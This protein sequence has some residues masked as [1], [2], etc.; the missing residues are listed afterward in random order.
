MLGEY[1]P[2]DRD[3]PIQQVARLTGTTSRTLRHYEAKGLLQPSRVATNG[4]RFYDA[5]TLVRLQR[6]LLL[7]QLG[8]SLSAIGEALA[9]Q[10]SEITALRAHLEQLRSEQARVTR[11]IAA[12]SRTVVV[13]ESGGELMAESMF[14]GFDHTQYE[15][16]VTERWGAGAY[17]AGDSWWRS[18]SDSEKQAFLA[19]QE[20]IAQ[21]FA[22]AR[23]EK[24]TP[25]DAPAQQAAQRQF[26]WLSQSATG[27]GQGP[28]TA[29]YFTGL[30]QMYV[31]DPRFAANYDRFGVG[32]AG[33]VR[34]AMLVYA[35]RNL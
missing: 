13:L 24:T 32:T 27:T 31:A 34:D 30:A 16:E 23:A 5:P 1:D 6:I 8:L 22:Q 29:E 14:E 28:V 25:D 2:T 35:E 11:Q 10:P 17:R 33:F 9:D 18:M 3:W 26:E 12:V 19:E 7:R 4:Y 21:A 20:Q 15:G